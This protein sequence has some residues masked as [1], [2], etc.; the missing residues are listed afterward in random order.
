LSGK[1]V[2]KGYPTSNEEYLKKLG[3]DLEISDANIYLVKP[4][5]AAEKGKPLTVE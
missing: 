1:D 3:L 5:L 2:F 4:F